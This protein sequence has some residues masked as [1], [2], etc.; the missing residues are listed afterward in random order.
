MKGSV[1]KR[2][3]KWEYYFDLGKDENG[4]RRKKSKGGF[5]TKKEAEL[6]L[7]KAVSDFEN[8]G[9]IFN[10]S[11]LSISEYMNLWYEKHVLK[12]CKYRTQIEYK[13]IIDKDIKPY[14]GHYY[15]KNLTPSTIQDFLDKHY[16]REI[17]KRTLEMIFTVLKYSLDMGVFPYELIKNNPARYIKLRYKFNKNEVNRI[18]HEN[19]KI[20]LSY[21]K[22]EYSY[23]Y[24][25]PYIIM[26]HTGLRKSEVLGLQWDNIDFENKIIKVQHQALY[27]DGVIEL[28][29]TKTPSSVGN[30]FISNTLINELLPYKEMLEEKVNHNFVC[31]NTNYEPMSR[32]NFDWIVRKIKQ[33]LNIKANAHSFRHLHG[34]VLMENK[35]NIKGIQKRLRH[36]NVK[37]TLQTYLRS[38]EIVD[39]DTISIWEDVSS[40]I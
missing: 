14:L 8:T 37:T 38:S 31:V 27:K 11:N 2:G 21:L 19:A 23:T 40:K 4:K 9:R 30:I 18:S 7:A 29:E 39:K 5:L 35:A 24:Y 28:V 6:A 26:Y 20:V 13:R 15:L 25:I 10:E 3:S 1:R 34:Q 32:S 36:S 12:S 33:D 22:A 16:E 17:S